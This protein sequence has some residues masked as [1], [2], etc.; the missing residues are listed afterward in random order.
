MGPS[1]FYIDIDLLNNIDETYP[2]NISGFTNMTNETNGKVNSAFAKVPIYTST[3]AN[4]A[5]LDHE[6]SSSV[7][8]FKPPIEKLAKLK[9]KIRYHNNM[10]VNLQNAN[11][12]LTLSINQVVKDYAIQ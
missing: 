10:L 12:S 9:V 6:I 7:S 4:I 2:F 3:N 1:Y 5:L 11:I 8:Y